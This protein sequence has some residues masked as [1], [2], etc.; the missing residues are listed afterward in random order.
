MIF[1]VESLKYRYNNSMKRGIKMN[2][3][4]STIS[5]RVSLLK[6]KVKG[7]LKLLLN[8][9]R[10]DIGIKELAIAVGVIIVIGAAVAVLTGNMQDIVEDVWDWL[11]GVLQ[12]LTG[13]Y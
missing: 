12:D 11:F 10:G 9:E 6:L 1:I 5:N 4:I 13:S 7:E 3:I 2:K 8:E